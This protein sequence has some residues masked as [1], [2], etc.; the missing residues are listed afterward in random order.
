MC[1]KPS[2]FI[3]S[4]KTSLMTPKPKKK[5]S[6]SGKLI[7]GFCTFVFLFAVS[8]ITPVLRDAKVMLDSLPENQE[9]SNPAITL[10]GKATHAKTL[11][12]NGTPITT[13]PDG[14]FDHT[15]LLSPGYNSIT[16]DVVGPLG[17]NKKQTHALVLKEHDTGSFAV[18]SIPSLQN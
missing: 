10:S 7:I 9:Y 5:I 14:S 6:L 15:I 3:S 2:N 8:R 17:K 13:A 18:S 16:F 11:T 1:R 4:K 12:L